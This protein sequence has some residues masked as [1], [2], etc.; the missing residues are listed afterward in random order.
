MTVSDEAVE[1]AASSS[2]LA[3]LDISCDIGRHW[4]IEIGDSTEASCAAAATWS[5]LAHDCHM[6]RP[7]LLCS[8]HLVMCREDRQPEQLTKWE[9]E[10]CGLIAVSQDE[11][12][13]NVRRIA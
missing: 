8:R 11:V 13:W 2:V 7:I 5:A 3:S 4:D 9:C 12:I 6:G 10:R 1:A